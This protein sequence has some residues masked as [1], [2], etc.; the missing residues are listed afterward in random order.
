MNT[1]G[2]KWIC[3]HSF[4]NNLLP[5]VNNF[6]SSASGLVIKC[7]TISTQKQYSM[8]WHH[9]TFPNKK[10][11]DMPSTSMVR[12]TGFWDAG[13]PKGETISATCYIQML[14]NL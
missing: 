5:R 1:K 8:E 12:G 2:H 9:M 14:K 11:R 4:F 6:L 3:Y 13:M 10:A 7:S